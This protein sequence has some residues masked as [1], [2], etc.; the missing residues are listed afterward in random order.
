MN[1]ELLKGIATSGY[2][3][4]LVEY[5]KEVQQEI[6]DIRNGNY[7]NEARLLAVNIIQEKLIGQLRVLAG[8]TT[9]EIDNW[10]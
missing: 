2:K 6:A 7:S 3:E 1:I 4:S 8:E 10:Q 9:P 5:L